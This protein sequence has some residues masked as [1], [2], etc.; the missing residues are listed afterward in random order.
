M[1]RTRLEI[2]ICDLMAFTESLRE[3]V[4]DGPEDFS[5]VEDRTAFEM[6]EERPEIHICRSDDC[7]AVIAEEHLG[8]DES[9]KILIDLHAVLK[10]LAVACPGMGVD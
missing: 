10:E 5:A 3:V 6:K 4:L 1:P 8:M 2:I 7:S 9:R